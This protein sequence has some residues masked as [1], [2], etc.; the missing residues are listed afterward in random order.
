MAD[1]SELSLIF[2][3]S[4]LGLCHVSCGFAKISLII[5]LVCVQYL[6]MLNEQSSSSLYRPI[7]N[8]CTDVDL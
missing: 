4:V 5:L 6:M 3:I 1:S 7:L 8:V 2:I